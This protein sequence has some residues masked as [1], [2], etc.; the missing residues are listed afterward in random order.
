[1]AI[2]AA[3]G[4][5]GAM[6]ALIFTKFHFKVMEIFEYLNILDNEKVVWRSLLAA[7][8]WIPIGMFVPHTLFWGE[9]E[10]QQI[11]MMAPS[12]YLTQAWPTHGLIDF[13]MD[14]CFKCF[15][16]GFLKLITV[17][18]SIAG[19]YRGG[20]I[21][22]LFSAGAAFGKGLELLLPDALPITYACLC[23]AAGINVAITRTPLGTTVV[24]T[25]LAGE[26]NCISAILA[27][28][29]VSYFA[30]SSMSIIGLQCTTPVDKVE[31]TTEVESTRRS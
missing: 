21:F 20:Y 24:L 22:P 18:V 7:F 10:F 15:L 13:E 29:L 14:S 11:S 8:V 6:M 17:S 25:S 31:L 19:G 12:S 30:T 9:T 3:L 16:V 26:Q 5:F 23:V 28:S 2:G 1:V 4:L 27:A